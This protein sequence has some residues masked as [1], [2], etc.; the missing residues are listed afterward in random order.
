MMKDW[1]RPGRRRCAPC[2]GSLVLLLLA[3]CHLPPAPVASCDGEEPSSSR[4]QQLASQLARDSAFEVFHHPLRTGASLMQAP[5]E[6]LGNAGRGILGKRLFLRRAG[7]PSTPAPESA[8]GMEAAPEPC[9]DGKLAAL[10]L[11]TEG[12][13]AL[14]ALDRVIDAATCRLDVMMFNW[15][16]SPLG[17]AIA[18]RLAARAGPNFRVRV[19]VDG[20]GN[21]IFPVPHEA[22]PAEANRAVSWLAQQP[23]VEVR[24]T[25][26][27][28]AR[29]DHRKLVLADGCLAWAGGRNFTANAFFQRHDVTFTV[30]GP[31][32]GDLQALFERFWREQGGQPADA[33]PPPSLPNANATAR[34]VGTGPCERSLEHALYDAIDGACHHVWVENPY[35]TDSGLINKLISSRQRG[36]DVRVVLTITHDP[37]MVCRANR[38]TANRLLRAGVAVYLY[39][40]YLHTKAAAVDGRWAYLGSGN[41][42]ALSLRC[43]Y[44]LGL[45]I[46]AGAVLAEVEQR[47]LLPDFCPA[48]QLHEP[49][50]LSPA[51]YASEMIANLFL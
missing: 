34:L 42:D 47:V 10:C 15:D 40:G 36:V 21:L 4:K 43:N 41:F 29:F 39:P 25:R 18:A 45:A 2:R 38:V 48:W 12:T 6:L 13:E 27:A 19:L 3:G 30:A 49:L 14:A 35:L 51:D 50:H 5:A 16:P 11:Y 9:P 20:G 22:T 23:H 17:M 26:N 37:E 33:L 32:A 31:L 1:G 28:F 24:R 44:E 8:P 46:T 7:L